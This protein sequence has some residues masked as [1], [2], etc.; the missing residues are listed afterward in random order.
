MG[1]VSPIRSKIDFWGAPISESA[2][3]FFVII[4]KFI[5]HLF[6]KFKFTIRNPWHQK[7]FSQNKAKVSFKKLIYFMCFL[8]FKIWTTIFFRKIW[9][10][11]FIDLQPKKY[12]LSVW[13]CAKLRLKWLLVR[14][15]C[16]IW[17]L[18]HSED[19][20]Q[21]GFKIEGGFSNWHFTLNRTIS[22]RN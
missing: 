5:L 8:K 9:I 16:D 21:M 20:T 4:L 7:D 1:L 10:R 3:W 22:T 18:V 17:P 15:I 19:V 12:V 6:L 14:Q 11:A 2:A 13:K